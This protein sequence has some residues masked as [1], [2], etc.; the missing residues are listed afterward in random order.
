M[1]TPLLLKP[2]FIKEDPEAV[3][4]QYIIKKINQ[5]RA[6]K[7]N[8]LI[9]KSATGTGKS[10]VLPVFLYNLNRNKYT[11]IIEPRVFSVLSLSKRICVQDRFNEDTPPFKLGKNVGYFTKDFFRLPREKGILFTS[12]GTFVR[13]LEVESDDTIRENYSFI[14]VDEAHDMGDVFS[15]NV[16][17]KLRDFIRRNKSKDGCPFL[18]FMS[19]TV[20]A[21]HFSKYFDA[22]PIIR[23]QGESFE[24]EKKFLKYDTADYLKSTLEVITDIHKNEGPGGILV[25]FPGVQEIQNFIAY[26]QKNTTIREKVILIPLYRAIVNARGAVYDL[27]FKTEAE[28]KVNRKI[29][30]ATN[31]GETGIT[32]VNLKFVVDTGLYKSVEFMH[33]YNAKY[34]YNKTASSLSIKQRRG[35]VGRTSPGKYYALYSEESAAD[36]KKNIINNI[37][38]EDISLN[39]LNL[40]ATD[41]QLDISYFDF[42]YE[43]ASIA[44][45]RALEKLYILGYINSNLTLTDEGLLAAKLKDISAEQM[46][47]V[48]A[49]Y[50]WHAPILDLITIVIAIEFRSKYPK[51]SMFALEC[52][53]DFMPPIEL[54]YNG[55]MPEIM[56]EK[57]Y[58]TFMELRDGLID[59]LATIG[60]D[61]FENSEKCFPQTDDRYISTIKQCL[62][63]GYKLNSAQ[64]NGSKY[65]SQCGNEMWVKFPCRVD[66]FIYSTLL[67]RTTPN[68][69]IYE[70]ERV[71]ILDNYIKYTPDFF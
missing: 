31:I 5:M 49:G 46:R 68:G 61:P 50:V 22:A 13:Q 55:R 63:E 43:P 40:L 62:Y 15:S 23:V 59:S 29:I 36:I 35:R 12:F 3:P 67:I 44:V 51:D 26:F 19:A 53:C 2:G 38:K 25:F 70:P 65:V 45:W 60:L 41:T 6:L 8:I 66:S 33:D 27:I 42:I 34:I 64:W 47:V 30:V 1:S 58:E 14:V 37:Y 32:Y 54:L 11:L 48:M 71:S 39:V 4:V 57:D 10:T 18:I 52:S 9:L 21:K 56:G 16:Y 24:I 7:Q 20:S 17:K 69:I 28:L